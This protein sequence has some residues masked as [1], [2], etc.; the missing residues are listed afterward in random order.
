MSGHHWP[1]AE[2]DT[3]AVA[4]NCVLQRGQNAVQHVRRSR[5]HDG[6]C[7]STA[8]LMSLQ[9]VTFTLLLNVVPLETHTIER[10]TKQTQVIRQH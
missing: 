9:H 4:G 6:S 3:E 2:H 7:C 5:V 10:L 8:T 1:S